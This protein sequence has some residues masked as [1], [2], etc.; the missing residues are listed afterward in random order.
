MSANVLIIDDELPIRSFLRER[1]VELGCTVVEAENAATA[2]KSCDDTIDLVLL[3]HRLPDE[4]GLT[5]LEE[6]KVIAP[7]SLVI[8]MTAYS[9]VVNAVSAMKDG[10]FHYAEKPLDLSQLMGPIR[11]ALELTLLRRE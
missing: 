4:D 6:L 7:G 1:L 3:D 9:S 11:Q 5:L 2:R 10:A 8:V